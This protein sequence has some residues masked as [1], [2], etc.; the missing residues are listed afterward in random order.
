MLFAQRPT[1]RLLL[2]PSSVIA[3][4][5]DR[6]PSVVTASGLPWRFS[7]FFMKVRAASLSRI[8]VT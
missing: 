5:Y 2:F 1:S 7:A 4:P 8:F 6:Y 3:A